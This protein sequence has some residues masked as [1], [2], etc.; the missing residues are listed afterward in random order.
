MLLPAQVIAFMR[1]EFEAV[2]AG[3]HHR[4][5]LTPTLERLRA[6]ARGATWRVADAARDDRVDGGAVGLSGRG[7]SIRTRAWQYIWRMLLRALLL[8]GALAGGLRLLWRLPRPRRVQAA[9]GAPPPASRG[10][11]PGESLASG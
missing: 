8:S 1:G 4:D 2:A 11:T 9:G 7:E 3:R 10:G 5:W 6:R